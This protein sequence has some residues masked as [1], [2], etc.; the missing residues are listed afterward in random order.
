MIHSINGV[1]SVFIELLSKWPYFRDFPC[2]DRRCRLRKEQRHVV[3]MIRDHVQAR[4][5]Q[6]LAICGGR[7]RSGEETRHL[8]SGNFQHIHELPF[9]KSNVACWKMDHLEVIQKNLNCGFSSQPCLTD[10]G[11]FA[12]DSPM[13]T[14]ESSIFPP[15]VLH[16]HG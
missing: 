8:P 14:A 15:E 13:K 2:V 10:R 4:H 9:G 11:F 1:S 3:T 5:Q 6:Q 16:C 12:N 7:I